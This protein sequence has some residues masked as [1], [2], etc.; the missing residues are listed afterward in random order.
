[1]TVLRGSPLDGY[2]SEAESAF[3]FALFATAIFI[4]AVCLT[5][6][7]SNIYRSFPGWGPICH[8]DSELPGH[9]FN[10]ENER[11]LLTAWRHSKA[12]ADPS[13]SMWSK[14]HQQRLDKDREYGGAQGIGRS[15]W[16]HCTV[17]W[18]WA[19]RTTHP[20]YGTVVV[21]HNFAETQWLR[22]N[23]DQWPRD[24]RYHMR[25]SDTYYPDYYCEA[26]EYPLF[27]PQRM[28]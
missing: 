3:W 7:Y 20:K 21:H 8:F 13:G 19:E 6:F 12:S 2:S 28:I 16:G 1:M 18:N 26:T 24:E 25:V 17:P 27:M 15:T 5:I 11:T 22:F 14:D 10:R 9:D 4:V 23:C